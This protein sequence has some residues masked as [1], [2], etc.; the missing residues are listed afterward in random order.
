MDTLSKDLVALPKLFT[1]EQ[2]HYKRL[3]RK[4]MRGLNEDQLV[5]LH[6][7]VMAADDVLFKRHGRR[8]DPAPGSVLDAAREAMEAES[9]RRASDNRETLQRLLRL[10]R[11][12]GEG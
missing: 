12:K 3:L 5:A 7:L 9:L 11:E 4:F 10:S 1:A 2:V 8:I 6:E